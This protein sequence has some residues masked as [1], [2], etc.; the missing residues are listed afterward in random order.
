M[1][2]HFR[3]EETTIADIHASYRAGAITCVQLTQA[4]LDR[5]AA[6]DQ[7]GEM[8]HERNLALAIL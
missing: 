2:E 3:V 5:I 7:R 1:M 4:Y 6:Y 8:A